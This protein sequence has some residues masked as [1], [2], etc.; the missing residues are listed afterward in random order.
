MGRTLMPLMLSTST[1]TVIYEMV[2]SKRSHRSLARESPHLSL[3]AGCAI[4]DYDNDGDLDIVVNCINAVPQLL[5][6]DTTVSRNF[7]KL[8]LVGTKSNRVPSGRGLW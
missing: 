5:R 7:L 4:G 6:C 1:C 3:L 8:R 2:S